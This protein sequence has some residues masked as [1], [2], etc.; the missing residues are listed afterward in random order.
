M[1]YQFTRHA[2]EKFDTL[3]RYGFKLA[4][5][6]VLVAVKSPDRVKAGRKGRKIAQRKIDDRHVLRVVYEE[7]ADVIKIVTFYPARSSRYED[8]I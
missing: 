5:E 7:E 2:R 4:E 1:K 8:K 6:Q 3:E